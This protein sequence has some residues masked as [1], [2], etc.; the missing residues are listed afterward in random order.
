MFGCMGLYSLLSVSVDGGQV[1]GFLLHQFPHQSLYHLVILLL[2]ALLLLSPV[3]L[4]GFGLDPEDIDVGVVSEIVG[5]FAFADF[6]DFLHESEVF[7]V[8]ESVM[9]DAD[10]GRTKPGRGTQVDLSLYGFVLLHITINY[11]S[12]YFILSG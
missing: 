8:N 6:F 9:E 5:I 10:S 3:S 7:L 12:I 4:S 11:Q 2:H 1:D